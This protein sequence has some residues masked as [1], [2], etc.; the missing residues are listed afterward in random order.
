MDSYEIFILTFVI[1]FFIVILFI[2][3]LAYYAYNHKQ[4]T[5]INNQIPF[6]GLNMPCS[7]ELPCDNNLICINGICKSPIGSPCTAL[8]QCEPGTSIC[9]TLC[10]NNFYGGINQTEPCS[11][12]LILI[13]GVCKINYNDI[14]KVDSDCDGSCVMTN[15][16]NKRCIKQVDN[17][18]VCT[19]N[20]DCK[21]NNCSNNICQNINTIT[22][23]N[24]SVCKNNNNCDC[25]IDYS[26][27]LTGVC[28]N[29]AT[30]W[31][32]LCN[33]DSSCIAPSI[34]WN[35]QCVMPRTNNSYATNTCTLTGKCINGYSCV[36][37]VCI[38]TTSDKKGLYVFNDFQ[39][40]FKYTIPFS[41]TTLSIN[42][43]EI[44]SDGKNWFYGKD[45]KIMSIFY[46]NNPVTVINI[47]FTMN[48]GILI[49]YKVNNKIG[50]YITY[51]INNLSQI[52]IPL[53]VYNNFPSTLTYIN[54]Y[55]VDKNAIRVSYINNGQLFIGTC[56]LEYI[57]GNVNTYN[58]FTNMNKNVTWC[59]I[60]SDN[61]YYKSNGIISDKNNVSNYDSNVINVSYNANNNN[62][63]YTFT[64]NYNVEMKLNNL[65]I[66]GYFNNNTMIAQYMDNIYYVK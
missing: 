37:G 18:S 9:T 8:S 26:N 48:N 6:T 5:N 3:I 28:A 25:Y 46:N 16:G 23:T 21:S 27:S 31:P 1:I 57:N 65:I 22:G 30:S 33:K 41:P 60:G 20:Y 43:T 39:W 64:F 59:A 50:I 62:M 10:A 17:G 45:I 51:D 47:S 13:N 38:D 44:Y 54:V 32:S 2:I 56:S 52:N 29:K 34:C 55:D 35:G 63:L 36:N 24:G 58:V 53:T 42:Y 14:C 40:I 11:N 19:Y 66:P 15:D 12:N 49:L 4:N 7:S 61:Y